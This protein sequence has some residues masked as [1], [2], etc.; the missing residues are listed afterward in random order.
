MTTPTKT[1]KNA[2]WAP[3]KT[4]Q[5]REGQNVLDPQRIDKRFPHAT[6]QT[7]TSVRESSK[8]P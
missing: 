5:L 4:P 6:F 8:P 2:P 7:K 3:K 1:T